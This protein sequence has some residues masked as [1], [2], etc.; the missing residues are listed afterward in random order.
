MENSVRLGPMCMETLWSGAR[1][2]KRQLTEIWPQRGVPSIIPP[3]HIPL[4][5]FANSQLP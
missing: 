5:E 1:K 4:K 2:T 3:T